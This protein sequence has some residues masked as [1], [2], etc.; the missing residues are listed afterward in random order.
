VAQLSGGARRV[1]FE[2]VDLDRLEDTAA[3]L[4]R[5]QPEVLVLAASRLTWWRPVSERP[6]RAAELELLPYGAWLPVHVALVREVMEARRAAGV[7]TRVVSLPFPDAVGPALAPLGLAPDMG[8]GNV[9]EVAA[10]LAVLAANHQGVGRERV[11]VRL[12]MH[13]AAQRLAFNAFAGL[14]GGGSP[15]GE[16]PWRG[17][18]EVDGSALPAEEVDSYVREPY[19]LPA[20]RESQELTAAATAATTSALLGDNLAH[21][22][23]PAPWGL[24]GGYPV[25]V[26]RSGMRLDLPA[27]MTHEEAVAMNGAAGRW[28]GIERIQADGTIVF[29]DQVADVTERL[30][31]LRLHSVRP[32]EMADTAQELLDRAVGEGVA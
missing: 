6:E 31:G 32:E 14:S 17:E 16:P 10:K 7:A 2:R 4:Q 1:V 11:L 22:H 30:L 8:A 27:G 5:F 28:D 26:S 15:E 29:T 3:L 23:V 13:H 19:P 9:M 18:M 20:G 25:E 21:L 24:P 12:V